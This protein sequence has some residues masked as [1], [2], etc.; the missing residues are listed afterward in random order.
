MT[1]KWICS[2]AMLALTIGPAAGT[3]EVL[4]PNHVWIEYS[5]SDSNDG[6]TSMRELIF[7]NIRHVDDVEGCTLHEFVSKSYR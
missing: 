4:V 7:R 6:R 5:L 3:Q 1:V 2:F